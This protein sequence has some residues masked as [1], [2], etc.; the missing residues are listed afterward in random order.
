M[1]RIKL[2]KEEA[3]KLSKL[4][5]NYIFAQ[6]LPDD[7]FDTVCR[8]NISNSSNITQK[9]PSDYSLNDVADACYK[10]FNIYIEDFGP[11]NKTVYFYNGKY[12]EVYSAEFKDFV[13]N[14]K[15]DFRIGEYKEILD[16]LKSPKYVP[17]I[18]VEEIDNACVFNNCTVII[19]KKGEIKTVDNSP[20]YFIKRYINKDYK[21]CE[22]KE[23]DDYIN[24]VIGN[25]SK[26]QPIVVC[27]FLG[28][29][30][31]A[32][33]SYYKK[34]LIVK[35]SNDCGKSTFFSTFF[36]KAIGDCNVSHVG[37][38]NFNNSGSR[39]IFNETAG[40]IVNIDDEGKATTIS[41]LALDMLKLTASGDGKLVYDVKFEPSYTTYCTFKSI[42]L[43]NYYLKMENPKKEVLRKFIVINFNNFFPVYNAEIDEKVSSIE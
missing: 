39:F 20:R 27:S 28:Y 14:L 43:Q 38:D 21:V 36:V 29:T 19:S 11:N 22:C 24:N 10:H 37:L 4:I 42:I 23:C 13:R 34:I 17:L 18:K 40:K 35:G 25:I 9:K 12:Y 7:E 41:N 1:A 8:D 30:I 16:R 15:P 31:M 6:P 32:S 33:K 2:S 5:N 3:F 26:T